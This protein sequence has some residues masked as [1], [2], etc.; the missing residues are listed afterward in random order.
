[1][2]S[3]EI[4][5]QTTEQKSID[6]LRE[7]STND[8]LA[9]SAEQKRETTRSS[10]AKIYLWCF[11]IILFIGFIF[12]FVYAKTVSDVK[13]IFVSISGVLSGPLGFIIGYYFKATKE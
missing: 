2:C 11:F 7:T 10:I 1:M 6:T 12:C 8:K 5:N 9:E 13:D 4:A 3:Q